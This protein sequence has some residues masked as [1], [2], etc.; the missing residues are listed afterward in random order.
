M[1]L[2][3]HASKQRSIIPCYSSLIENDVFIRKTHQVVV[4]I[5]SL[6]FCLKI[7]IHKKTCIE[8]GGTGI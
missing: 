4:D 6:E 5:N 8:P 1:F 3:Q 7:Q 2:P